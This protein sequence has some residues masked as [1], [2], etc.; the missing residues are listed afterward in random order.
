[1]G[2]H[3][4]LAGLRGG[5]AYGSLSPLICV[6]SQKSQR[7]TFSTF[8]GKSDGGPRVTKALTSEGADA[9]PVTPE[10]G[11]TRPGSHLPNLKEGLI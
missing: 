7:A 6:S 11:R 3:V 4:I 9:P 5:V 2:G 1:M 10:G 8:H